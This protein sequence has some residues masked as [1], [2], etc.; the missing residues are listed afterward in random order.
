MRRCIR[1]AV[2]SPTAHNWTTCL[3][4]PTL[5]ADDP[6]WPLAAASVQLLVESHRRFLAFLRTRVRRPEDAEEILQAAFVKATENAHTIRDS[7][8]A[9]AWFYRLLRNSL[10]DYYRRCDAELRMLARKGEESEAPDPELERTICECLHALLPTLKPEY[11]ELIRRVDL[12]GASV[13]DAANQLDITPNNASVR[14]HRARAA[15]KTRLEQT[16][17]ACTI[18]GCLDCSCQSH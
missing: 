9:V 4:S 14:L 13:S 6:T 15:L 8:S 1:Y 10:V 5:S 2:A 3:R 17:G 16:C 11:A 18:H 12:G 7:E